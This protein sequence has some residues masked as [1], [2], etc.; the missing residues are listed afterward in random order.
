ML[1][2]LLWFKK[3]VN[4]IKNESNIIKKYITLNIIANGIYIQQGTIED[5]F[6]SSYLSLSVILLE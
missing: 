5:L 4:N 2:L 1:Y 3:F 6:K